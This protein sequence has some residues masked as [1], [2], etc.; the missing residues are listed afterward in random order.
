MQWHLPNKFECVNE[1]E[2]CLT[3]VSDA[4]FATVMKKQGKSVLTVDFRM[5]CFEE[6]PVNLAVRF[7]NK[8]IKLLKNTVLSIR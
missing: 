3:M 5:Q 7:H 8:N 2:P 4:N 6:F 1:G